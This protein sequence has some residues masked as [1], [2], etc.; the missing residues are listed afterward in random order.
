MVLSDDDAFCLAATVSRTFSL[1]VSL[2]CQPP[3]NLESSYI[4]SPLPPWKVPYR[5]FASG[6]A[7]TPHRHHTRHLAT[8]LH[9][10]LD[11]LSKPQEREYVPHAP[12][13]LLP[14]LR[15]PNMHVASVQPRTWRAWV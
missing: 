3:R 9:P 1:H 5:D 13:N 11:Q 2:S 12:R 7:A 15:L 10:R 4:S 14:S 8:I 6:L